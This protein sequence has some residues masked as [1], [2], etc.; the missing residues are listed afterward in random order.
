MVDDMQNLQLP[1]EDAE[2]FLSLVNEGSELLDE[3]TQPCLVHGDLW[4]KNIPILLMQDNS[5]F[6]L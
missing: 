6:P 2:E 5:I 4:P 1:C 3:V